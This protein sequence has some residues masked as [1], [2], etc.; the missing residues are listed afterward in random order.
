[1]CNSDSVAMATLSDT[2][3]TEDMTTPGELTAPR[4]TYAYLVPEEE[5]SRYYVTLIQDPSATRDSLVAAGADPR[6]LD[7]VLNLLAYR[8][9]IEIALDGSIEVAPPEAA[10]AAFTSEVEREIRRVRASAHQLGLMHRKARDQED[11]RHS[12]LRVAAL[13][14]VAEIRAATTSMVAEAEE[15]V[16]AMR[17]Y[18]TR[19][20]QLLTA[21][22]IDHDAQTLD[23]A[24]QPLRHIAVYDTRLLELDGVLAALQR[25]QAAG[26]QIRLVRDV[27]LSAVVVDGMSAVIDLTNVDPDGDGS[28]AVWDSPLIAGM[29]G[30]VEGFYRRGT[31][32]PDADEGKDPSSRL[33]ARDRTILTLLGSGA[34]DP[35]VARQLGVSVRTVE[36]RVRVLMDQLDASSR[37]QLGIEAVRH[38]LLQ[39]N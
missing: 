18:G 31:P 33:T 35:M 29:A 34:S 20:I 26:E 25:R 15:S 10:L 6:T 9:L 1:M 17:A 39:A 23:S 19:S 14:S 27:P 21:P 22:G 13:R 32:L 3:H 12:P 4:T 37:M 38:G 5:L 24:G 28:A 11:A 7:R 16:L 2:R 30:M 8:G 36:R